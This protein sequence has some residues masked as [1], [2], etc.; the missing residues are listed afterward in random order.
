MT[1]R[2]FGPILAWDCATISALLR[3]D[4]S[5]ATEVDADGQGALA[6]ATTLGQVDVVRAL[7]T[8][9]TAL[10]NAPFRCARLP[11]APTVTPLTAALLLGCR[12]VARAL[13]DDPRVDA[14]LE[15]DGRRAAD[16]A[17]ARGDVDALRRLGVDA[18][19]PRAF[20][21]RV[22]RAVVD[23]FLDERELDPNAA[24]DAS[25]GETVLMRACTNYDEDAVDALLGRG[26]DVNRRDAEGRDALAR[27]ARYLSGTTRPETVDVPTVDRQRRLFA[28]LLVAGATTDRTL[29]AS[30][31]V[32]GVV[33]AAAEGLRWRL[34]V[35]KRRYDEAF[36]D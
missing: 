23:F 1:P 16:V 7:L 29:D 31:T 10:R 9:E 20:A 27:L 25:T 17:A 28:R 22:P 12:G 8:V 36:D 30:P 32:R 4:P 18:R 24:F 15:V 13:L 35:A 11:G 14:T 5:A 26:A 2:L 19:W 21:A 6:L 3:A 34:G 33:L